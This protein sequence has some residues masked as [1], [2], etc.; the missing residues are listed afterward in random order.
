MTDGEHSCGREISPVALAH[1]ERIKHEMISMEEAAEKGMAVLQS[2]HPEL[3]EDDLLMEDDLP[4]NVKE[5]AWAF[6]DKVNQEIEWV[7]YSKLPCKGDA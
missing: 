3:F 6:A 1:Y 5:F 7:D 2:K 4:E